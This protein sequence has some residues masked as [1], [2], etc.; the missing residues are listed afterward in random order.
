MQIPSIL[1]YWFQD[2][3]RAP[4]W[5]IIMQV[6]MGGLEPFLN[7]LCR[8]NTLDVGIMVFQVNILGHIHVSEALITG[9]SLPQC[10]INYHGSRYSDHILGL[11]ICYPILVV[12]S[13]SIESVY[14]A[15][16]IQ[17]SG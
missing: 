2:I 6:T 3:C 1:Q 15:L 14:L 5:M 7:F 11:F 4:L 17:I 12:T 16:S 10:I 13:H 8:N 9:M